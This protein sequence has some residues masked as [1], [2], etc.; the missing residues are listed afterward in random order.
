MH[1]TWCNS[2]HVGTIVV[3]ERSTHWQMWMNDHS[4]VW[5]LWYWR[6]MRTEW[7]SVLSV[8]GHAVKMDA[9]VRGAET[10]TAI[11]VH[12]V[13]KTTVVQQTSWYPIR[14]IKTLLHKTIEQ[15]K[16][17]VNRHHTFYEW[18]CIKWS[19]AR[20]SFSCSPWKWR[21][22][23]LNHT[24]PCPRKWMQWVSTGDS[25]LRPSRLWITE[26]DCG[27][28]CSREWVCNINTVCGS[29]HN[30][31]FTKTG[32]RDPTFVLMI[33][34][35]SAAGVHQLFSFW[36]CGHWLIV[37]H[38]WQKCDRVTRIDSTESTIQFWPSW[39]WVTLSV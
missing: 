13:K 31:F 15:K 5:S 26:E 9:P 29:V 34:Y 22:R 11:P 19:G 28:G 23:L 6:V 32:Y 2:T 20:P 14:S 16:S 37:G 25:T 38:W 21:T 8:A 1:C 36:W 18:T 30:S 3:G 10:T 35:F 4:R 27:A 39:F 7:S 24:L 33:G 17:T 12:G